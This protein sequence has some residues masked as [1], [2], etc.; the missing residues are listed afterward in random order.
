MDTL[1]ATP[2]LSELVP[3]AFDANCPSR[4][5]LDLIANKWTVLVVARL[6]EGSKRHGELRRGVGGISQRMLTITLRALEHEGLVERTVH[7][8]V[9]PGVE[10][11]LTNRGKTLTEPL[12]VLVAWSQ[13]T[14]GEELRRLAANDGGRDGRR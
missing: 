10:Y 2:H 3:N 5:L 4:R 11:A 13:A 1:Q 9:P 8:S 6:A 7:D 14:A 12:A